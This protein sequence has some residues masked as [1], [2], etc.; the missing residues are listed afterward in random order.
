MAPAYGLGVLALKRFEARP[1][2]LVQPFR[3]QDDNVGSCDETI[4]TGLRLRP[5]DQAVSRVVSVALVSDKRITLDD[6]FLL[7]SNAG[8]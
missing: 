2:L 4:A 5:L 6:L 7:P 3:P 8:S 1:L